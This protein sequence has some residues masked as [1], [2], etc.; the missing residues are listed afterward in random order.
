MEEGSACR[1][2]SSALRGYRENFHTM[3]QLRIDGEIGRYTRWDVCYNLRKAKGSPVTLR[4]ASYGGSIAD[5]IAISHAIQEHGDVTVIHDSLNASAATWLPFGAKSIKMHEDCMLYVHCSSIEYFLWQQ[6]NAEEL[7]EL[8]EDID[9]EIRSLEKMD[10]MIANK[11]AARSGKS[12]DEMLKLMQD[13]PWL[14][15]QE[16]KEYGFVD[17]VIAEPSGKKVTN[18]LAKNFKNCAIPMPEGVEV[19]KSLLQRVAEK[20]GLVSPKTEN[21]NAQPSTTNEQPISTTQHIDNMKTIFTMLNALLA[22]VGFT[23]SAEGNFTLTED[24][25]KAIDD[26]L[27]K[28][29]KAIDDLNKQLADANSAKKTAE[30]NLKEASDSL[31]SLSDMIKSIDGIA[32]KTA[33]IKELFDKIP[34]PVEQPTKREDGNKDEYEDI[35]KDPINFYEEE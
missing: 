33:K 27:A 15:A 34:A 28:N 11:Y 12:K 29:K 26:E 22:V 7:K 23:M 6:M 30:D 3:V 1:E 35:R 13:H 17:E 24:Q 31:D 2:I 19:E 5:A 4:I 14:T 25:M 32:N 16:C 10:E 18:S 8:G 21:L 20:L 9:G